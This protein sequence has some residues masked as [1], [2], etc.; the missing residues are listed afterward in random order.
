MAILCEENDITSL[1]FLKTLG[2]L[3]M[4]KA[5]TDFLCMVVGITI[6]SVITKFKQIQIYC[7]LPMSSKISLCKI[8]ES[9][10]RLI[11]TDKL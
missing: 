6:L 4:I 11:K 3:Y 8:R 7:V 10:L 2:D 5:N 1:I 9:Y